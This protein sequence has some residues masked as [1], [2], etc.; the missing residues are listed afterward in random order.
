MAFDIETCLASA[1]ASFS[2][3]KRKDLDARIVVVKQ[4]RERLL[5]DKYRFA[6]SITNDMSKPITQSLAEVEKCAKLCVYYIE[7]SK[8][9]LTGR[10]IENED[11]EVYLSLE[12]LGVI[13]GVMPWN[14]PFWQVF[15]F[16]IPTLLAGN[17]VVLKHASNVPNAAKDLDDLFQVAGEEQIYYNLPISSDLVAT[18]LAHPV[19]KGVSLTGSEAAGKSVAEVAGRY[20]KPVLLE[21]GGSNAF[22]ICEDVNLHEIVPIAV[23]ARMQNAGQSCIA[24]KRFL[25]HNRLKESFIALFREELQKFK[26]G[27][28]TDESTTFGP[29]ARVDLAQELEE[30]MQKSIAM[31]ARVVYGGN[32]DEAFFEPTLLEA[33]TPDMP[34]FREETFGPLAVVLGFESFD[35]AVALSNQSN[36][37]LGVSLFSSNTDFLRSR[38]ADFNEGALFINDMVVSDPSIP[39]G[40]IKNSGYGREMSDEGML[41]FV[42]RKTVVIK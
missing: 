4:I 37:G 41:A 35:E 7:E 9:I 6:L 8:R 34:V 27:D 11:A 42:N 25:V 33:V 26:T 15:R 40:G 5:K 18:V 3:W 39:F 1:S 19:V 32:R 16:A 14:Y 20:L 36:Y 29:M 12:P 30:Q 23:R 24:A 2:K 28:L 31:G 17:V 38:I 22:I 13:L 21:L 10:N